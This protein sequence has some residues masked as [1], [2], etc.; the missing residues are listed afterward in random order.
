MSKT[1]KTAPISGKILDASDI[2]LFCAQVALILKSGIPLYDGIGAIYE[3]V[4][5]R[6]GKE[7]FR[8]IYEKVSQNGTLYEA[9]KDSSLF[10]DYMVRMVHIGEKAGKLEEVMESLSAYYE[11]E[12][13]IVKKVKGAVVYPFILLLM[14]TVVVGVLLTRVLPIFSEIFSD[15]GSQMPQTATTLMNIGLSFGKYALIIILVLL[16]CF[17]VLFLLARTDRGKAAF[18]R[19]F[20]KSRLFKRLSDKIAL[21]RFASIVALMISSGF[22][23]D[24][25]LEMVSFIVKNPRVNK[26]VEACREMMEN[27]VSFTEA[28]M[29]TEVFAGI[30]LRMV[31][32]GFK[33]GAL[34]TVMQK[35]SRLYEEEVDE[36]INN[37]VSV[38]EPVMVAVLSVIIG[39]ILLS[40]ML[41]LM[42][43]MSSMG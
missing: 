1:E 38:I 15:L 5:S 19:F 40:V 11:R 3:N 42:G 7:Q 22:D 12:D 34:D 6:K 28:M 14:M 41:P 32:V 20:N 26:K 37:A 21:A 4:E 30:Y 10:P 35:L 2:S 9:L 25:A 29:K 27:G 18:D 8:E 33:A 43:I 16:A 13:S 31:S 36:D 24:G 23:T 39:A 17:F